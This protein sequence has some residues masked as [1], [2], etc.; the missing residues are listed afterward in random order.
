M[1]STE[2]WVTYCI[3]N[4]H[5]KCNYLLKNIVSQIIFCCLQYLLHLLVQSITSCRWPLQVF[6]Y[7]YL[8]LYI[9][10]EVAQFPKCAMRMRGVAEPSACCALIVHYH[11]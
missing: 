6:K 1:N 3:I 9:S 11:L 2:L 8:H 10:F 5:T 7:F 4:H